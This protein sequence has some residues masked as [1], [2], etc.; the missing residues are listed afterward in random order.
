MSEYSNCKCS[1]PHPLCSSLPSLSCAGCSDDHKGAGSASPRRLYRANPYT[2][3]TPN[4]QV[5]IYNRIIKSLFIRL[6]G[7]SGFRAN[8]ITGRA[9]TAIRLLGVEDWDGFGSFVHNDHSSHPVFLR[10]LGI[11]LFNSP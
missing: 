8:R 4:T 10:W 2:T 1:Q 3:S 5:W 11:I 9:A 6:H 7:N